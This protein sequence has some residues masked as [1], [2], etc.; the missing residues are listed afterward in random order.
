MNRENIQGTWSTELIGVCTLTL[1]IKTPVMLFIYFGLNKLLEMILSFSQLHRCIENLPN[2]HA[3]ISN[4]NLLRNS[5]INLI[6]YLSNQYNYYAIIPTHTLSM[7]S[8]CISVLCS[9]E[10]S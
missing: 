3:C 10:Y 7:L 6:M 1:S 8:L 4:A 9:G 2:M 5:S